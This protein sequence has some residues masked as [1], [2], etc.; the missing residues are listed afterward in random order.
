MIAP[1]QN[2][3]NFELFTFAPLIMASL[4]DLHFLP[5]LYFD[6]HAAETNDNEGNDNAE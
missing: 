6:S 4:R 2:R 5:T 1:N 3:L